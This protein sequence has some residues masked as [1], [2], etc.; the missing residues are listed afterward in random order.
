MMNYLSIVYIKKINVKECLF[1][2][3]RFLFVGIFFF[4]IFLG[5]GLKD[6]GMFRYFLIGVWD[7]ICFL[8]CV[9]ILGVFKVLKENV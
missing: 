2:I 6:L 7:L 5:R 9:Y 1:F 3:F 4:F 8:N